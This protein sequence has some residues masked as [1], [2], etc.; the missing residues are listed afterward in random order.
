[1]NF[2][3]YISI[4]F[5]FSLTFLCLFVNEISYLL[6]NKTKNFN[7]IQHEGYIDNITHFQFSNITGFYNFKENKSND[8]HIDNTFNS[9]NFTNKESL[10]TR[11]S[12]FEEKNHTAE[13]NFLKDEFFSVGKLYHDVKDE[14][15]G[16]EKDSEA[17]E[18]VLN[19]TE[20]SK[21]SNL[22]PSST[23]K[24][25]TIGKITTNTTEKISEKLHEIP[26]TA[27]KDYDKFQG[28][29]CIS[30]YYFN[31]VKLTQGLRIQKSFECDIFLYND[32]KHNQYKNFL[33]HCH[34][35]DYLKLQRKC[36]EYGRLKK[37]LV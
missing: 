25:D 30:N 29:D 16:I 24:Q 6:Q 10:N 18:V 7:N 1:M 12:N 21:N 11:F 37:N 34:N 14:V 22:L 35:N 33:K 4:F 26:K 17:S 13:T 32:L 8:N 5:V 23:I 28:V 3:H 27:K 31:L 9:N 2:K 36:K 19:T 20:S 15:V